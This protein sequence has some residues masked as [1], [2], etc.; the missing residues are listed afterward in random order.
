MSTSDASVLLS[1]VVDA[2]ATSR[3]TGASLLLSGLCRT[4]RVDLLDHRTHPFLILGGRAVCSSCIAL[5]SQSPGFQFLHILTDVCPFL[6]WLVWASS[7]WVVV[8]YQLWFRFAFTWCLVLLSIFSR[9][10]RP[11][12]CLLWRNGYSS[13]WSVFEPGLVSLLSRRG[14]LGILEINPVLVCLGCHN[15]IL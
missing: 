5:P 7:S 15:K 2:A 8:W 9:T 11:F 13:P 12:I 6:V 4:C 10:H 1:A 14:S 3:G